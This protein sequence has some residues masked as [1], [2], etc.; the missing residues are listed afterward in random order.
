MEEF[1][2]IRLE[3]INVYSVIRD[4]AWHFWVIILAAASAWM[5]TGAAGRL[6]YVPAY[7]SSATFAVS[8]KGNSNALTNL[9]LTNGLAEVFSTVFES[10]VLKGRVADAMGLPGIEAD[11]TAEVIPETNLLRVSVTAATP[12]QA[13]RTL[14][15]TL[16]NYEDISEF[17]FDNAILTALKE[18]NVPMAPSNP[19][20]TGRYQKEAAAGG[21]VLAIVILAVL[22]AKRETIQTRQTA[23]HQLEGEL[24]GT[25][26]HDAKNQAPDQ[27]KGKQVKTAA[28]ITNPLVSYHF[29]EDVQKLCSRLD[30]YMKKHGRQILLISSAAENEGK[31]TVAANLALALA[32]RKKKVLLAD[33]DFRKPSQQKIFG[34]AEGVSTDFAAWLQD[35]A[36]TRMDSVLAECGRVTL[37]VNQKSYE[38]TQQLIAAK[39]M[40]QFLDVQKER[41]DYI[42]LDS[43]PM[44]A[45]TD[46]EALTR[47][48]EEALLVVRQDWSI[49]RDI[50]D[51]IDIMRGGSAHFIGYVL[52]NLQEYGWQKAVTYPGF[53]NLRHMPQK[54]EAKSE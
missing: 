2:K 17:L 8:T 10:D 28:L 46:A 49:I 39:A 12:E 43:P 13:F 54:Q 19:Q 7:T 3:D 15:L 27:K 6:T 16:D 52:N 51:C 41:F 1:R 14:V 40:R 18:P 26:S 21:A 20:N 50:N 32:D 53:R 48:A 44:L 4:V 5:L 34:I 24:F 9:S 31:S 36:K 22:S 33:C 29:Q 47:V 42:I 23:R 25:I 38:K 11:I 35:P 30:Y 37:T 45:A